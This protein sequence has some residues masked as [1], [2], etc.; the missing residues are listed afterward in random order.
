MN[1][2]VARADKAEDLL[3]EFARAYGQ[4]AGLPDLRRLPPSRGEVH[5][6]LW[7][8][9]GLTGVQG[10][11]LSRTAVGWTAQTIVQTAVSRCHERRELAPGVN[12]EPIWQSIETLGLASLPAKP[13]RN[14][15]SAVTDG[16]SYVL[17][18]WADGRYR[19]FVYDNPDVFKTSADTKMVT[20]ARRLLDA[21]AQRK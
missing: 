5:V 18:W 10:L 12:W 9:F 4:S 8:G 17:E 16:Y 13:P 14:P 7:H 6:R 1:E 15:S 11:A 3:L 19:A 2:I 21:A 20:I